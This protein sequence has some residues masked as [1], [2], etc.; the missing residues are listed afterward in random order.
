MINLLPEHLPVFQQFITLTLPNVKKHLKQSQ[1]Q[2]VYA[3]YRT[4]FNLFSLYVG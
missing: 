2:D 1:Q 3:V 4:D